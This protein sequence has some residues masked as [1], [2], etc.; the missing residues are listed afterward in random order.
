MATILV[1]VDD[2]V[3]DLLPAW[4]E[5]YNQEYGDKLSVHSI[6]D[7]DLTLFVKPEC[8]KLIYDYLGRTDLYASVLPIQGA[9]TALAM[10]A[11]DGHRV[12][13]VTAAH[14]PGKL[15]WLIDNGFIPA[16]WRQAWRY[17]VCR[18]KSLIRG[19]III[20]DRLDT[21]QNFPGYGV[22]FNR[23][24]NRGKAIHGNDKIRAETWNQVYEIVSALARS[25]DVQPQAGSD[26]AVVIPGLDPNTPIVVNE[27]GGK[28]SETPYRFDLIDPLALFR[29]AQVLGY[30]ANKY[31]AW[32]W[33]GVPA[34]DSINHAIQHLYAYLAGDQSD[35]HLG[36]AFTRVHFALAQHLGRTKSNLPEVHTKGI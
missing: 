16:D 3:A 34:I 1:D 14:H 29:L 25:V 24:H 12:L 22:L 6:T 36:H 31:D 18:D 9:K 33:L 13:Y 28:Q 27:F 35:D 26:P 10:L 19:D 17:I 2:T 21:V 5:L 7:W 30:G 23:H 4:I 32:N 8:G 11:E 20:D 15:T